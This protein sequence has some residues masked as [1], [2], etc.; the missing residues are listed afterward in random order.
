MADFVFADDYVLGDDNRTRSFFDEFMKGLVHKNNNLL[1]VVQ[2]F[3]SLILSERS[4]PPAFREN[5]EQM[6]AAARTATELNGRLLTAA[7][8]AKI[9]CSPTNLNDLFPFL[10]EKA[11]SICGA[12]GVNLT[13]QADSDLPIVILDYLKFSEVY[14][15]LVKNAA[16]GAGESQEKIVVIDIR[17]AGDSTTNSRVDLFIR[18]SCQDV[19]AGQVRGFF[20]SFFSSKS[21]EHF[22]IGL[23]LA[24]VL[25]GQMGLRLG[26]RYENDAMTTWV[27][28][29][30]EQNKTAKKTTNRS[31]ARK[32]A[33]ATP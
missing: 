9:D 20:E 4:L 18:N 31:Q 24:A 25:C 32:K 16:E 5:M 1:G 27:A 12:S 15:E 21:S 2:G 30:S 28:I 23:S 22:G 19:E 14:E 17:S 29:P 10:K 6:D 8:C 3:G 11:A 7:G 33:G 26:L 13:F